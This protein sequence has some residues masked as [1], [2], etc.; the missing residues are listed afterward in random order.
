MKKILLD[1]LPFLSQHFICYFIAW[2]IVIDI[3]LHV[4]IYPL[5]GCTGLLYIGPLLPL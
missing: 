5:Q 3:T 2:E 1:L 4:F